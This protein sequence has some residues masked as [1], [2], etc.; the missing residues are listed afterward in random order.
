KDVF[1]E[2]E[3]D[4]YKE[5][6]PGNSL[7]RKESGSGGK[8]TLEEFI[9]EEENKKEKINRKDYWLREGIIVKAINPLEL[10]MDALKEIHSRFMKTFHHIHRNRFMILEVE[11]TKFQGNVNPILQYISFANVK[12]V[13]TK[14]QEYVDNINLNIYKLETRGLVSKYVFPDDDLRGRCTMVSGGGRIRP[15]KDPLNNPIDMVVGTPGR[16]LQHIEEGN[17]VYGD[18]KYLVLNEADIMFDRG[19][20]P[21]ICKF[22]APLKHRASKSDGLGFLT[23]LVT[24]T[25][26]MLEV[27]RH[28]TSATLTL[29][30][31]ISSARHN[32]IKLSGSENKLEALLQ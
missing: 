17:L 16:I 25:M 14:L 22:L 31:R 26:T 24:A 10:S 32:F 20:G 6:N 4:K 12:D 3:E 9:R 18:I 19:F 28:C 13:V 11:S 1:D 23:I 27:K 8:S 7:K 5:R 15:Q 29:H 2:D 30:K 21:D